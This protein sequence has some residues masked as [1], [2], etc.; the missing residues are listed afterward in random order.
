MSYPPWLSINASLFLSLF[1][2]ESWVLL[3][4]FRKTQKGPVYYNKK[5]Y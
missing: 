2:L 3:V 1:V 4:I 5:C